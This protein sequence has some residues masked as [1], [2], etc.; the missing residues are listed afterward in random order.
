MEENNSEPIIPHFISKNEMIEDHLWLCGVGSKAKGRIMFVAANTLEEEAKDTKFI[1]YG[2]EVPRTPRLL[3]SGF[4]VLF[5]RLALKE[6]IDVE[7]C[8]Y[9]TIVKYLPEDKRHRA[10]PPKSLL[11]KGM[12]FVEKEIEE[13]KPSIIVAVGKIAFDML[14]PIKTRESDIIGQWFY[15]KKYEAYVYMIPSVLQVANP[16]KAERFKI[17]FRSIQASYTGNRVN[18]EKDI[19]TF[20]VKNKSDLEKLVLILK[21][22]NATIL[23]VDCEWEG[24]QHVDGK[25]RSL[26]IAWSKTEA[27]YIR[28]MD[29]QLNYAFDISYEEAG[30]ILGE[31]L[32]NKGVKYIGHHVSADLM[33]MHHWLKLDWY[34]KAIFDTEF[35]LQCCDESLDLGLDILALRY[36]NFGKYD[37]DLI[38]WRKNNPDKRGDGYGLVPDEILI[39]YAVKDVLTVFIAWEPISNW[40]KRQGLDKYYENILNP[41]VT[42]VFTFFGLKGIPIDREKIDNMRLLYQWA[43]DELEKDFKKVIVKESEELFTKTLLEYTSISVDKIKS[44]IEEVR[45]HNSED[46][47]QK[48]INAIG[49][50]NW[51]S[52]MPYFDHLCIAPS[53]NIRSKVHMVRWLFEVK[54][55]RP[56]KSTANKEE[57]LPAIDWEKVESFEPAVRAK[58]TPASDKATIEILASRY[59]DEVLLML[60]R[61]NAIGNICKAFL[62]PADKDEDGNLVK[63]NGL[64]AWIA[65]DDAIHLMHSC[66]ETGK[67]LLIFLAHYVLNIY[68]VSQRQKI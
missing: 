45:N 46:T 36:T 60:L 5:K 22:R 68:V 53:F 61:L 7:K 47:K 33:W 18:G 35:A 63:E 25:L 58:Y 4:G 56:V 31:W 43:K 54:K 23:S 15:N 64:H 30:K 21:L 49:I 24:I 55:Y 28:F 48:L 29:D 57:G 67:F 26:Q 51:A 3:D 66:T 37:W 41:F 6:G 27:A 19:K 9:T 38:W 10:R 17:D 13:L 20:V 62:K 2:R 11:N 12:A 50:E 34:N 39:P 52:I 65:S 1:G 44:I 16:E 8:W 32:N 42:N 40:L 14:V 59:S